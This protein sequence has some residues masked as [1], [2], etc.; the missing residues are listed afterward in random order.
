MK[1]IDFT[2]A[3]WISPYYFETKTNINEDIKVPFY[4]TD[5][6]QS[7][8]LLTDNTKKFLVEVEFN[9]KQMLNICSAGDNE[10]NIGSCNKEGEQYF[11][12]QC[13]DL[14]NNIKSYKQIGQ[15]Y[16]VNPATYTKKTYIMTDKDLDIYL[17][18]NKGSALDEDMTNNIIGL[19]KLITDKKN[20]GYNELV[21]LN[22]KYVVNPGAT[23]DKAIIVPSNFTLNLNQ[24]TIKQRFT[25]KGQSSLI[26][27]IS[28][29]AIDSH[30]IN[31]FI[32]GDYDE[33]NLT[34]PQGAKY[35]IEGEGFNSI[36]IGGVFSSLENLDVSLVT[37]YSIVNSGMSTEWIGYMPAKDWKNVYIDING[38]EI[39]SS[40]FMT[41]MYVNIS[42]ALSKK[43]FLI[44]NTMGG[45]GGISG[46]SEIEYI[47]FYDEN[48]RYISTEKVRQYSLFKAPQN[49]KYAKG[50]LYASSKS[51]IGAGSGAGF[52]FQGINYLPLSNCKI[53]NVYSHDTRTCAM[54]TGIY[55]FLLV[56]GCKFDRCGNASLPNGQRVTPVTVDIEDGYQYGQNYFFRNNTIGENTS[57]SNLIFNYSHNAIIENNNNFNM[58]LRSG[59]KGMCIRNSDNQGKTLFTRRSH[60]RSAF[61]RIYNSTFNGD[62]TVSFDGDT[63][64]P[65]YTIVKDCILNSSIASALGGYVKNPQ[66]CSIINSKINSPSSLGGSKYKNCIITSNKDTRLNN[67]SFE[68][69]QIN[70]SNKSLAGLYTINNCK[71]NNT[72]LNGYYSADIITIN[73]SQLTNCYTSMGY[74][75]DGYT[76]VYYNC[77][78]N[79]TISNPLI[80]LPNYSVGYPI[81]INNCRI[82]LVSSNGVVQ[83]YDDRINSNQSSTYSVNPVTLVKNIIN[84]KNSKYV[85]TGLSQASVNPIKLVFEN[86]SLSSGLQLYDSTIESNKKISIIKNSY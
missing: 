21:L 47:H 39:E 58:E 51:E 72:I 12:L 32:E 75:G 4:I 23:R 34:L 35:P 70:Y 57:T 11:T 55:N 16:V 76:V 50:T 83:F 44:A 33:H 29:D 5:Y 7:E 62:L 37:G 86:N 14:S 13:T 66:Y 8:Y 36:S 28:D 73:N 65:L 69:C 9:G 10:I 49:T 31:G 84:L 59:C 1:S 53:K 6:A 26:I 46:K 52:V 20:E 71:V 22:G 60:D 41:S 42:N 25:E 48:Y 85:V 2:N 24:S 68:L 27:K 15:L 67:A 64:N 45:Y 82:T 18:N 80:R 40:E 78:I 43:K 63:S 30:I 81:T 61:S 74:W 19:N 17:L 54:A 56:E 79:N 3:P 38:N 77:D